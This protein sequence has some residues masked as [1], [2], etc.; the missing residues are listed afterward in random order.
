MI[1]TDVRPHSLSHATFTFAVFPTIQN[2][3][4]QQKPNQLDAVCCVVCSSTRLLFLFHR[5]WKTRKCANFKN[6]FSLTSFLLSHFFSLFLLTLKLLSCRA[7]R[8]WERQG[9]E[10]ENVDLIWWNCVAVEKEF[11]SKWNIFGFFT[12]F[13]R[14]A[15]FHVLLVETRRRLVFH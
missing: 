6:H 9:R 15:A 3:I 8:G 1:F 5:I 4:Q 14:P 11:S 2:Q 13:R 10:T 7:E 12:F